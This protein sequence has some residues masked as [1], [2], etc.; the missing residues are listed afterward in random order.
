M[1][2]KTYTNSFDPERLDIFA[3]DIGDTPRKCP[4]GWFSHI[5]P[6]IWILC[7]TITNL[8]KCHVNHGVYLCMYT[9]STAIT[10]IRCESPRIY[11]TRGVALTQP[12][13]SIPCTYHVNDLLHRCVNKHPKSL[14]RYLYRSS[15]YIV[16]AQ[17][18][19]YEFFLW[20]YLRWS[21]NEWRK[22]CLISSDHHVNIDIVMTR[23]ILSKTVLIWQKSGML[24]YVNRI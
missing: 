2:D 4:T 3:Q 6:M 9:I 23:S 7:L 14:W 21:W 13:Q 5:S 8:W 1:W 18:G 20:W 19:F 12:R 15:I 10:W 16:I 24:G 22:M 17:Q 11:S